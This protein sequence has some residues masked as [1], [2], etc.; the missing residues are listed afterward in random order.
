MKVLNRAFVSTLGLTGFHGESDDGHRSL[1]GP[2]Q[3]NLGPGAP[4][5]LPALL[6]K[7]CWGNKLGGE[8]GETRTGTRKDKVSP[9]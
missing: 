3:G 4:G 9:T 5:G 7:R 2:G 6:A 1:G 8:A